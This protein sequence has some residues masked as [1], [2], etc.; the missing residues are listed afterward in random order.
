MI[1]AMSAVKPSFVLLRRRF[2]MIDGTRPRFPWFK[3][4]HSP[5][6]YTFFAVETTVPITS[7]L[8]AVA[9]ADGYGEE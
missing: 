6:D 7:A 2:W 4:D 5:R 1:E 9:Q 3:T 8:A